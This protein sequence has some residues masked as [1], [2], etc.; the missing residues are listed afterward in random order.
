MGPAA[1]RALS[2]RASRV[3]ALLLV[4]ALAPCAGYRVAYAEHRA[5][6]PCG[7]GSCGAAQ[8][9]A[10]VNACTWGSKHVLRVTLTPCRVLWLVPGPALA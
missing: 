5:V 6:S 9:R 10:S 2:M 8:K 4:A 3:I 1:P 7:D